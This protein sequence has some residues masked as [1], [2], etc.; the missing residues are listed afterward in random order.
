MIKI[1]GRSPDFLARGM[2]GSALTQSLLQVVHSI[3]MASFKSIAELDA[4]LATRSYI[5]GY[6]LS[7]ADTKVFA[8]YGASALAS[9][10]TNKNAYRW[11]LHIA[12][13]SGLGIA[14]E[15][16][17]IAPTVTTT[18]ASKPAA[19][20]D[21]FDDM[22]GGEEKPVEAAKV[23]DMDDMFNYGNVIQYLCFL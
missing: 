4:Y 1:V 3:A 19:K 15:S 10:T 16:L 13:L 21:D 22:F 12:A 2:I 5:E 7:E 11:G 14:F 17:S 18:E 20:A 6:A 8:I 23:A 9:K